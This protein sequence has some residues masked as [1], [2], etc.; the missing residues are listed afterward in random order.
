MLPRWSNTPDIL[1]HYSIMPVLIGIMLLSF[2]ACSGQKTDMGEAITE[3]DSLPVMLTKDVTTYVS[4]SGITRYKIIAEE[5]A[6]FDRKTPPHW[7]FEKGVYLEKFDSLYRADASIEADTAYNYYTDKLWKLVGNV[8]IQNI[9]GDKFDTDLLYWNEKTQR[10]Y[11]DAFIRIDQPSRDRV[12]TGYGFES[13]QQMTNYTINNVVGIFYVD[14]AQK[15]APA[16]SV[17]AAHTDSIPAIPPP[18]DIDNITLDS[19]QS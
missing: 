2:P 18:A 9:E 11:S 12:I 10:V 16:D 13:D 19:L 17:S 7:A 6:V 8:H 4:D 1:K 3:R 14:D 5:W 15:T